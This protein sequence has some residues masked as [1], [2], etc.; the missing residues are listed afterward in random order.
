MKLFLHRYA[1]KRG[2]MAVGKPNRF[3]LLGFHLYPNGYNQA[4]L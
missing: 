3:L 2:R 1:V 4:V